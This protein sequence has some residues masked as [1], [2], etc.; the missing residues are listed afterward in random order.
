ML[1]EAGFFLQ[2]ILM[3]PPQADLHADNACIWQQTSTMTLRNMRNIHVHCKADQAKGM[4]PQERT[5]AHNLDHDRKACK[6]RHHTPAKTT[7]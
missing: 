2:L 7:H 1:H 5:A 6:H 4:H 3:G